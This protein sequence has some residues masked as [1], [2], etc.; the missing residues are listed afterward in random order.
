MPGPELP[1]AAQE[2]LAVSERLIE[3]ADAAELMGD[4]AGAA[5]LR[6]RAERIHRTVMHLLDADT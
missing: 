4:D 3:L 5:A 1:P 2:R 6:E